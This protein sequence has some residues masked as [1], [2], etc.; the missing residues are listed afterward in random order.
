MPRRFSFV[1]Y[2]AIAFLV[3]S[4]IAYFIHYL[5]FRDVHHIFIYMIG[6]LAFVPLEV[7]L[8]VLIIERVLVRREK[9]AKLQ[10]LNMVV[11][12]F[13]TEVGV[14][15]F[16]ASLSACFSFFFRSKLNLFFLRL[17]LR[18][19]LADLVTG[20]YLFLYKLG[21]G[22]NTSKAR[23]IQS[24]IRQPAEEKY[25]SFSIIICFF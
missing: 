24:A 23:I 17:T 9:Q 16:V 6:D 14:G 4:A 12:A 18:A 21:L 22:Y 10:K 7:L 20:I 25:N 15:F 8:V 13:F 11:G 1:F 19:F 3:V 2:L 5:I